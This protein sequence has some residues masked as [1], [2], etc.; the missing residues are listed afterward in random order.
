MKTGLAQR[1]YVPTNEVGLGKPDTNGEKT[2]NGGKDTEDMLGKAAL[3][4]YT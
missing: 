3:G 2:Y 4:Q 1:S